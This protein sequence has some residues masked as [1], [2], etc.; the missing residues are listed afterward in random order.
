M[1]AAWVHRAEVRVKPSTRRLA[2]L[3]VDEV[4][5]VFATVTAA[6]AGGD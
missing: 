5:G 4:A 2:L 3:V 6:V 1:A